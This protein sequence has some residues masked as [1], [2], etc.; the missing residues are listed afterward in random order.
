MNI[1]PVARVAMRYTTL[2]PEEVA[3][4]DPLE[5]LN[6]N[7]YLELEAR[8]STEEEEAAAACPSTSNKPGCVYLDKSAVSYSGGLLDFDS[9]EKLN[10]AFPNGVPE[11]PDGVSYETES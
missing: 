9:L 5:S 4:E 6:L 2:P 10:M 3:V 11:L 8:E 1:D 7:E